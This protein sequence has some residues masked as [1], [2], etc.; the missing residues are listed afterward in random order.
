MPRSHTAPLHQRIVLSIPEAAAALSIS[1]GTMERIVE[2]GEVPLAKLPPTELK[3][4]MWDDLQA[5]CLKYRDPY[6]LP[7]KAATRR[8]P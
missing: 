7:P 8:A 3:R 4:I 5:Y 2:A 1:T 6:P